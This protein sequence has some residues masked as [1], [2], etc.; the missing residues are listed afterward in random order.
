MSQQATG[1]GNIQ[2][3]V[4]ESES[5]HITVN[6]QLA[7]KLASPAF[8]RPIY[9]GDLQE[10][11]LLKAAHAAVPF[12]GRHEFLDE[13][14]D[15]CLSPRAVSFRVLAG[16][17]GAGKTRFA[18]EFYSRMRK[19][20][21]WGAYFL[22]FLKDE[23]KEVALWREIKV[24]NALLIA[25]YAS[26]YAKPLADLLRSL[27]ESPPK[28][29]CRIR[30]LLMARTADWEQG[31]LNSL[32][33]ARTGEEV[34]RLF[35]PREPIHLPAFTAEERRE[36]FEATV[37]RFAD[38]NHKSPPP[39][40]ELEVFERVEV[41]ER[42][43]DPLTLMMAAA[44]ALHAGSAAALALNRTELAF[45]VAGTLVAER[46]KGA[47]ADHQGLFLHLAAFAT[48]CGGLGKAEALQL[49]SSEADAT[50]LGR[51]ADPEAF[52]ERLQAWLPAVEK[53]QEQAAE[54]WIGAIHP[55]IVGE[56]FV[57]GK[58]KNAH[59]RGG[60]AAVLRAYQCRSSGTVSTVIRAAQDFS[61]TVTKP[62]PEPLAWVEK[63]IQAAESKGDLAKM[64]ELS[65]AMP[66]SSVILRGTALRIAQLVAERVRISHG[67]SD[68]TEVRSLLASSLNRL[69]NRQSDVGQRAE[70][71]ATA[72]EALKLYR[73]L[74]EQNR[75]AFLPNLAMSLNNLA[76]TQSDVGLR[77]E[78]LA[79][80]RESLELRRE[81]AEQNRAAFLPNL[82]A[83]LNNLAVR[84][85]GVGLRA[86]ALATA[87][88]AVELYRE[89]AEQNRAAFLPDLAMSLNNLANRQNEVGQRA[90]ALATARE[91][92][93]LYRELAEQNRAA[94]LPNLAASL[95]NLG[96]MQRG[97]GQR[98]EALATTR[99]AVELCRQLAQQNRAA[100]LPNVAA[101]LN[102]LAV[103]QS[104][105]GLRAEALATAHEALELS[106]ELTEQNRA[107]FLPDLAM[108]LN[109]LANR[110]SDLGQ[111]ADALA[112]ARE[113]V[114]LYREL[115]EQNR[116]AFLPNLAMS[117]NNLANMQSE[118]GQRAMAMAT[119]REAVELIRELAELN[120]AAF[121][122]DLAGSLTNLANAQ[123][124]VGQRAEALATAR[125]GVELYRALAEQSRATFAAD[126][127]RANLSLGLILMA[128]G[129]H[130]D[131]AAALA[132]GIQV[133]IPE[134]KNYPE[135]HWE[136]CLALVRDYLEAAQAGRVDVDEA[137]LTEVTGLLR[138]YL[139]ESH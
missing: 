108:S 62:R 111:S 31:W 39:I 74:A 43:A 130:A 100:F 124:E 55:D 95:N 104:A 80:A 56:A 73:E 117:L 5:V 120:Q 15:W 106:R 2:I 28:A 52:L 81:L 71:L 78:A 29:G 69:S 88:E 66:Q 85:S 27:T 96:V 51:V 90:E 37:K 25:D 1:F 67:P 14:K 40:P 116:A 46:M 34:D 68:D 137:L 53:E 32:K 97:V 41:A 12:V 47:V 84:Q 72:H 134:L 89:L 136:L 129:Q 11:D 102:N 113:A 77:T 3:S 128:Q 105:L 17:G 63:L 9:E 132:E 44:T 18:F 20:A 54:D 118:V 7:V 98:V 131:A 103:R 75:A 110:Q 70:A 49:L 138:P 24:P 109:N 58:A 101:S 115:A 76:A 30:V 61:F 8:P 112:T 139:E 119:A 50:G 59:L 26:D 13:C 60:E 87:H 64:L 21:D 86:E 23:A 114:E 57:I 16:Q 83:S 107:A 33:S 10:I 6:G 94:F 125:E 93:D 38:V 92:V 42:L 35:H 82:A 122:P 36:I 99:E 4:N 65:D 123:S 127:A 135:A 48:L 22:R 121:L 91:A 126:F 45:E 19:Q 79:T 133:I